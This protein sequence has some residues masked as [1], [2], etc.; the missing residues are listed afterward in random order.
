[1]DPASYFELLASL[2]KQNPPDA[3]DAPALA[4]YRSI[5]LAAGQGFDAG[6][7]SA[8]PGVQDVPKLALERIMAHFRQGGEDLNGWVFFKP[9]GRYGTDYVQRAIITRL[10]L[11]CNLLDD[12]VYPTALADTAGKQFDGASGKLR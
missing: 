9:A 6:K 11:G 4:R 5:G 7:L 8:I 2:M 10:G 1:M 12:A 3:A